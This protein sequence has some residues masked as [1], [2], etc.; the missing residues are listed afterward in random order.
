MY[1]GYYRRGFMSGGWMSYNNGGGVSASFQF[2]G[3]ETVMPAGFRQPADPEARA[4]FRY[5]QKEN[6]YAG[7]PIVYRKLNKNQAVLQ[8]NKRS[9]GAVPAGGA[10]GGALRPGAGAVQEQGMQPAA[11]NMQKN[12][13]KFNK[14]QKPGQKNI[15]KQKPVKN[16]LKPAQQ[17]NDKNAP[18]AG[19]DQGNKQQF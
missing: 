16:K 6:T 19:K 14:K 1:S 5:M 3:T 18:A 10:N 15:K 12:P 4:G 13:G 7:H 2:H 17:Q 11:N 9:F 8:N